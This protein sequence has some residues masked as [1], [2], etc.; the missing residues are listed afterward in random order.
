MTPI[1]DVDGLGVR[2][3]GA[4]QPAL[5]G[6]SLRVGPGEVVGVVGG[7]GSGRS[8]LLRALVGVVPQL[9][10]A[11]VTGSVVVAGLDV[12]ATRVA[13]LAGVAAL[14]FDDPETQLSQLTV[15][16]EVA[17]GLENLGV[18]APEMRDRVAAALEACGLA[19]FDGRNPL[20]LSGGEQQRLVVASALPARPR[21]LLLDEPVRNL[22]P[23]SA[24]AV[25]A[26]A[27][28]HARDAGSAVLVAANDLDLLAEH[29]TRIVVLAEGR[30]VVDDEPGAAWMRV[31]DA[32]LRPAVAA[33]AARLEPSAA[34][35]PSTVD[36]LAARLG[37]AR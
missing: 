10:A 2:Y 7:T 37:G 31:A 9:V 18:P 12:A 36:V 34:A 1:V 26:L 28:G 16:E 15:D 5:E 11:D 14:V 22:D 33:L 25:L 13:D 35:L 32:W 3:P 27:A 4:A 23:R 6:V 29:A 20:T 21:L 24:R 8:T 17:F 30:F 19:G